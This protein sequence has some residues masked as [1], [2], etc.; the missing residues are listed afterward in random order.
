[1]DVTAA[2]AAVDDV[3]VLLCRSFVMLGVQMLSVMTQLAVVR[4]SISVSLDDVDAVS[5]L[6][7]KRHCLED[8]ACRQRLE[9][10][11]DVCGDNSKAQPVSLIFDHPRSGVVHWSC[12][13]VCM[14][15]R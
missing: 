13:S 14:S 1:M 2:A 4:A 15:V 10:I 3:N 6:T 9:S 12:L 5:C 8:A 11:D 7:A